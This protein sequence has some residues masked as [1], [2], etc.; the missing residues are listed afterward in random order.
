MSVELVQQTG[1]SSAKPRWR[2]VVR[3][4]VMNPGAFIGALILLVLVFGALF[5]PWIAPYDW[6]EQ[7]VGPRLAPPSTDHF[8]GTDRFG[9]DVFSRMI[10]GG[11]FSLSVGIATVLFSMIIGSLFGVFIGYTGGRV[12]HFGVMAIDVMLGFPPIVLAILIVAVLGVGLPNVVV[13][14]GIAGIPR[15]ARVVRGA[16]LAIK[17]RPFVEA[18]QAIGAGHFRVM[19]WHLIPNVLPTITV[20]ATLNLAGAIIS[21]ASLS[22]LGLGAQPPTPE[23]GA[24]L[25]QSREFYRFA[26]WNMI[27][28][29]LA[30]FLSV[31]SVNLMGDRL[32]EVLDPRV[33][34]GH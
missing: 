12:D 27:F 14:V 22:F 29:G 2:K 31:M 6:N 24:M 13:A 20:L 3:Q 23:W 11:R 10:Y 4:L 33:S 25:Y 9:R 32:S 18:T 16:T 30:L 34:K 7:W 5:A 28:P 15:F 19:V 21:T 1:V 8:F 17:A 26:P